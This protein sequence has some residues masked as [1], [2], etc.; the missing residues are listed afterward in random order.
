MCEVN[1]KHFN[2]P[3]IY[4][5]FDPSYAVYSCDG[6]FLFAFS[7]RFKFELPCKLANTRRGGKIKCKSKVSDIKRSSVCLHSNSPKIY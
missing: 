4:F 7:R 6:Y 5:Y 2:S 1:T 3:F